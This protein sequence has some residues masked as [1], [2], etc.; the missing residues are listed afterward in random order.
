VGSC[1]NVVCVVRRLLTGSTRYRGS[2]PGIDNKIYLFSKVS[3]LVLLLTH[4]PT[5]EAPRPLFLGVKQPGVKLIFHFHLLTKF[6][7]S[8]TIKALPQMPS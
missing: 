8:R 5:Q 1:D 4:T 2:T 3:S 6:T 7:M